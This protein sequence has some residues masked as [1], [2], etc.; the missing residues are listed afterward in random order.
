MWFAK[1]LLGKLCTTQDNFASVDLSLF[2]AISIFSAYHHF[3]T[4]PTTENPLNAF[5]DPG[6]FHLLNP[7]NWGR[8]TD[9]CLSWDRLD[10]S[11]SSVTRWTWTHIGVEHRPRVP[12]NRGTVA[13]STE[14]AQYLMAV[15]HYSGALSRHVTSSSVLILSLCHD[16]LPATT[17]M[18]IKWTKFEKESKQE[19]N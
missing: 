8:Q 1:T 2:V 14:R 5:L 3:L 4:T 12:Y 10:N 15:T 19:K 9:L 6:R 7:E 16:N 18:G 17:T 11:Q 13:L